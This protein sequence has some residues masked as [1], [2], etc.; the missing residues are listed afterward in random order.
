M[1]ITFIHLSIYLFIQSVIIIH[2]YECII[3]SFIYLFGQ[4]FIYLFIQS[5]SHSF[6]QSV[7]HCQSDS[8]SL[9]QLA[10]TLLRP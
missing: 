6:S 5:V 3:H 4:S 2:S 9:L 1:Y 8:H 10:K 7:I